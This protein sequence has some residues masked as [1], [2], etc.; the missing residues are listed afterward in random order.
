MPVANS[1]VRRLLAWLAAVLCATVLG[2]LVQTQRALA[3][4]ADM[5]VPV[6]FGLRLQTSA[7]DL[8]GFGPLWG[9]VVAAGFLIAL[10]VAGL[11]ARWR[12]GWRGLLFPLAGA[13]ALVAAL[14]LMRQ[15]MGLMP[16][17]GARGDL[18]LL[19]F[20]LAGASGGAVYVWLAP[21]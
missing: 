17:A 16:V 19:L 1:A 7:Q 8:L 21:R 4:I 18:G 2:S 20:A 12:P 15:L 3:A 9:G 5:G 14:L 10:P 11:L 6:P 13:V